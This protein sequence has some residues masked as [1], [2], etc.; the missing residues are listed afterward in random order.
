MARDDVPWS[1]FQAVSLFSRFR[2]H[3]EHLD[4]QRSVVVGLPFCP[5]RE[6]VVLTIDRKQSVMHRFCVTWTVL[7]GAW[8][9]L[10]G[11]R[12]LGAEP[13]WRN[14]LPVSRQV[15]SPEAARMIS[16][17]PNGKV[18][19]RTEELPRDDGTLP[20]FTEGD[21][22]REGYVDEEFLPP[23]SIRPGISRS[24]GPESSRWVDDGI[25]EDCGVTALPMGLPRRS[26]VCPPRCPPRNRAAR[27]RS[28]TTSRP[29]FREEECAGEL[30]SGTPAAC[31]CTRCRQVTKVCRCRTNR[32]VCPPDS[33][34]SLRNN[35][36][37]G[38]PY[39][40]IGEASIAPSGDGF[41]TPWAESRPFPSKSSREFPMP[42]RLNAK[43]WPSPATL[44]PSPPRPLM[45]S[46]P[47]L[48]P[49]AVSP[50]PRYEPV[51]GEESDLLPE[52]SPPE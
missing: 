48:R 34:R 20:K 13:V 16:D 38:Q 10:T 35:S 19:R 21:I 4:P 52:L 33:A 5:F 29:V 30:A 24:G 50:R 1:W 12:A 2:H 49:V 18:R 6:V 41:A 37:F 45:R 27:V 51:F 7:M 25:V 15:V 39:E 23:A 9:G 3:P 32:P 22:V 8:I 11:L 42:T 26:G 46:T 44:P 36:V 40:T 28:C 14:P 43:M 17:S 31:R 47:P